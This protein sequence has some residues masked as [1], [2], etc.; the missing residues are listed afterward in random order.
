[1]L[2][3][4]AYPFGLQLLAVLAVALMA[5][6]LVLCSTEFAFGSKILSGQHEPTATNSWPLEY[7]G[8]VTFADRKTYEEWRLLNLLIP[9]SWLMCVMIALPA[10]AWHRRIK[11][12]AW[13]AKVLQATGSGPAS[14]SADLFVERPDTQSRS[15]ASWLGLRRGPIHLTTLLSPQLCASRLQGVLGGERVVGS[16]NEHGAFL[17]K[18]GYEFDMGERVRRANSF[19][20]WLRIKLFGTPSGTSIVCRSGTHPFVF[21]FLTVWFGFLAVVGIRVASGATAT[22]HRVSVLGFIAGLSVL[23]AAIVWAC[24]ALA[25][26]EV[27]Y[28]VDVVAEATEAHPAP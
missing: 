18:S 3:W 5:L 17:C 26:G 4:K 11:R 7:K 23:G 27:E 15:G 9:S 24:R 22:M 1:M 16:V 28:L 19:R 12:R 14:G 20:P 21:A 6:F 13:E 8:V 2:P 25:R 10:G